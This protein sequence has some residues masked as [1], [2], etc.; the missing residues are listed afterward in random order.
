M[1]A[2][3]LLFACILPLVS[4][5]GAATYPVAGVVIDAATGSPMPSVR[6]TVMTTGTS[7]IVSSAVTGKDGRFSFALPRG[8]YNLLASSQEYQQIYGLTRPSGGAGSSIITGEGQ[9][10]AHLIFRWFRPGSISG[11]VRDES[12][13]PV[14]FARVQ[15]VRSIMASGRR[16]TQFFAETMTNDLGEYRFGPIPGGEFYVA[17]TAEPWYVSLPFNGRN[18][19]GLDNGFSPLYYP[20]I[21]DAARASVLQLK[22][23]EEARADFTLVA[24]PSATVKVEFSGADNLAGTVYLTGQGIA[25]VGTLQR[26]QSFGK[27]VG[28]TFSGI[29]P[30]SYVL[31][32]TAT[33]PAGRFVAV[34]TIDVTGPSANCALLMRPAPKISGTVRMKEPGQRIPSGAYVTVLDETSRNGSSAPVKPDGSFQFGPGGL[35]RVKVSLSGSGLFASE[36]HVEGAEFHDGVMELAGGETVNIT[37]VA[38]DETGRLMGFAVRGERPAEGAIVVLASVPAS[39]DPFRNYSFQ[40]DSDGSFDF[41]TVRAGEY[42]LFAAN[43]DVEYLNPKELARY[44]P[45]AKKITIEPHGVVTERLVLR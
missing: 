30:G 15:L 41:E 26:Q 36:V 38:S 37:L 31:T 39:G 45:T 27:P 3:R 22:P 17:V 25:G 6:M 4:L 5:Q 14:E 42:A 23:G 40:T 20:N 11:R 43:E 19:S 33:A 18:I 1:K 7:D 13:E 24:V 21:T 10:T 8:K 35:G 29:P 2:L 9:D 34:Q 32:A 28:A 12:G 16:T 44:L